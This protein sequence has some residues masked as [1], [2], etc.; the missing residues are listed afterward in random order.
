MNPIGGLFMFLE[1]MYDN[2]LYNTIFMIDYFAFFVLLTTGFVLLIRK[3]IGYHIRHFR[4]G[5][6]SMNEG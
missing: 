2:S 6:K 4:V 3:W 5:K 1:A